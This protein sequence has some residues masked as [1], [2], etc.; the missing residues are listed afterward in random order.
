M[1]ESG[2]RPAVAGLTSVSGASSGTRSS[3]IR[4]DKRIFDSGKT[5]RDPP[6]EVRGKPGEAGKRGQLAVPTDVQKNLEGGV[7]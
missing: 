5:R 3:Y 1:I 7:S 2:G 4:R 6:K